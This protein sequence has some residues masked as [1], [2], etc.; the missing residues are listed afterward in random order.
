M[1]GLFYLEKSPEYFITSEFLSFVFHLYFCW[2]VIIFVVYLCDEPPFKTTFY[3]CVCS[4]AAHVGMRCVSS[5]QRH[6]R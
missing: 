1:I 6:N 5:L 3:N 4:R 2:P